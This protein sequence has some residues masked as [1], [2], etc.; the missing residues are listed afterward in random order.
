MVRL[1][2]PPKAWPVK[3]GLATSSVGH[4]SGLRCDCQSGRIRS[5]GGHRRRGAER[6]A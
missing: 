6:M 2:E 3:V 5:G 4:A 1:R